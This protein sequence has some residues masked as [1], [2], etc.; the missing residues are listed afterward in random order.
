MLIYSL[1]MAC[2][3]AGAELYVLSEQK[4]LGQGRLPIASMVPVTAPYYFR[5]ESR[6][7]QL[8]ALPDKS[9][10]FDAAREHKI[11]VVLPVRMAPFRASALQT[12]GWIPDFQHVYLPEFFSEATRAYRDQA[13][14]QLAAQC[15]LVM[16]SSHTALEHFTAFAPEHAHKG[17][18][19]SFPSLW[20]FEDLDE[21]VFATQQKFRIPAKFA[22]VANQFWRHK[23]HELVI[24]AVR[25]L[26][27]RGIRVHV[28][29]TGLPAD[30]RDPNNET[31]SRILQAVASAGLINEITVLG[32]VS[33]A[34]LA[35]LVR[36]AAVV[37]QPSRFEGWSSAVQECKALGRPVICSDIPTHREQAPDALGFVPCDRPDKLADLLAA[38]WLTLEPGPNLIVE[39]AALAAEREFARQHGDSLLRICQ[40][41]ESG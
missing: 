6:L 37:I 28:V 32:M 20:A 8:L 16:L 25:Q 31:T 13:Y 23:N 14:L 17:R 9:A 5:G 24:E 30:Y 2:Q 21:N 3:R 11:S 40:E 33:D 1:G 34:D 27:H 18:V 39:N 15:A 22:L 35:N 29:M 4:E 12:I 10:L 26:Q 19:I 41:A 36:T 38:N 7:R